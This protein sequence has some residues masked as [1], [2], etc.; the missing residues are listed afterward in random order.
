MTQWTFVGPKT[1]AVDGLTKVVLTDKSAKT[2]GV[3]TFSVVGKAGSFAAGPHVNADVGLPASGACFEAA[4]PAM[5]S[6]T[7][8]CVL[9]KT[10][11]KC[12]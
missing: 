4:F 10:T 2:P 5:P 1:G 6:V 8:S 3:V 11:P 7:P 9:K 12:K